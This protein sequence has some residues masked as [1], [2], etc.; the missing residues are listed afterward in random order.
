METK[1]SFATLFQRPTFFNGLYG[2][3]AVTLVEVQEGEF[4][5]EVWASY[6]GKSGFMY[7]ADAAIYCSENISVKGHYLELRVSV[8]S[9]C[10][11]LREYAYLAE[12][13][14]LIA[15]RNEQMLKMANSFADYL[16]HCE[17][18]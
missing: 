16:K 5:I 6:N 8:N 2:N 18:S 3:V 15:Y 14:D 17:K 13:N 10:N 11:N 9:L 12:G 7:P 4:A 1:L